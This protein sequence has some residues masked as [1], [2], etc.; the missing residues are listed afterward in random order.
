MTGN[1][2]MRKF[3]LARVPKRKSRSK[4]PLIVS[5]AVAVIALASGSG[6]HDWLDVQYLNKTRFKPTLES[7]HVRIIDGDTIALENGIRI[8]LKGID[9]P[10]MKQECKSCTEVD[11]RI[12]CGVEAKLKLEEIIGNS[13]VKCTDEGLD[14]YQRQLSYCYSVNDLTINPIN[15]NLELVKLGYA[16]AYR[17]Q[18]SYLVS[19]E[20]KAR[21]SKQGLW[22]TDFQAPWEWRAEQKLQSRAQ[23]FN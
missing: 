23:Q 1:N 7:R 8:R 6:V 20:F 19:Q 16:Q 22:Q 4:K 21:D 9:A 15:L 3:R 10:E 18:N 12:L 2:I 11:T 14:V 5:I 17:H 13:I